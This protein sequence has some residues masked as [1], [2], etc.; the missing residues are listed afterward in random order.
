MKKLSFILILIF[1]FQ[2]VS[3]KDLLEIDALVNSQYDKTLFKNAY[4]EEIRLY[5]DTE[6]SK[7]LL[8][9]NYIEAF[10]FGNNGDDN[11]RILKLLWVIEHAKK[12]DYLIYT[13]ANYHLSSAL[14][15]LGSNSLALRYSN[16]S[17]KNCI[18]YKIHTL[19]Y[20]NYSLE[21]AI[22]YKLKNYEKATQAYF[23][24]IKAVYKE[25]YLFR[26]SML[27][28]ISLCKMNLNELEESNLYIKKSLENIKNI[29]NR[30]FKVLHFKIIVEGNLG[31]NYFNQKKYNLAT[32]LLEKEIEFYKTHNISLKEANNP[33]EGLL[34][35]YNIKKNEAKKTEIIKTILFAES[36]L[37]NRTESNR[38]TKILYNYYSDIND[39]KNFKIYADKL[40][41][42]NSYISDSVVN[43][44]NTLNNSLYS[45]QINHL[46]TQFESN[47]K[48]LNSTIKGKQ[49][50]N[51][52]L[53]VLF[54]LICLIFVIVFIEKSRREKRNIVISE[55]NQLLEEKK[56]IIL[57]NE[58]KLKQEKITSLALNLNLKKETEKAFL[59]KIKE[60]K[61]KRN[62]EIESVLR[63]LQ[64]S[65]NNLLQIDNKNIINSQESD[66]ENSKF[67]NLLKEKHPILS[68]QERSFCTYF[69]MNLNSKEIASLCNMTSGTIRVY[70]TKIKTKIGLENEQNL[71]EYLISLT[72]S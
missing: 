30:N 8:Q 7:H 39:Y 18:K 17:L 27:N 59:E 40:I 14:S 56:R 28:N 29:K 71:N 35:I 69:R 60:I 24:A 3:A 52:F 53:I 61:R 38:F 67:I 22:N 46:K 50:T 66:A 47:N 42:N 20:L 10:I 31:S 64:H 9:A 68:E 19:L 23:K 58:I 48:L 49:N 11:T 45:Q 6:D 1:N 54:L 33:L 15:V 72:E 43:S 5:K 57:E 36:S 32:Q 13:Y 12:E 34:R 55:Q 16:E 44:L 41:T 4:D 26:A 63:D 70:K 51:I 2:I 65:V 25:D 62:V 21:G 37:K